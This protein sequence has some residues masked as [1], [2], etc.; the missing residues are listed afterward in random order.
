[1]IMVEDVTLR[2]ASFGYTVTEADS[3]VLDFIITKVENHIKSECNVDAVPDGLH[4]IAVDMV[5]GEFLLSK[6]STGQLTGIDISAMEKSIQEGDTNI[7]FAFGSGD[8]TPEKRLDELILY[9]MNY[10][11]GSFAS[12]R[13]FS[14]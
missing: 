5:V 4:N 3:W 8:K 14:W 12:Y 13:S 7:T 10:G 1:M 11:K 6:K 2:L 9:L